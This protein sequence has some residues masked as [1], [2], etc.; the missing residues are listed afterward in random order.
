MVSM[1]TMSLPQAITIAD[2]DEPVVSLGGGGGTT[3]QAY[4]FAGKSLFLEACSLRAFFRD[5]Y[6]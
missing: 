3:F 2:I 4:D 6:E 1:Q 5:D